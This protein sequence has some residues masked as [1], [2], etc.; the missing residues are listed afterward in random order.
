MENQLKE[1]KIEGREKI[2]FERFLGGRNSKNV[3]LGKV[4]GIGGEGVVIQQELE[5]TLM[6]GTY[7]RDHIK[8]ENIRLK[9]KEKKTVALKFVNFVK[10]DRENFQGQ[11][12]KNSSKLFYTL[13]PGRKIVLEENCRANF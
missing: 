1:I 4:L 7:S 3:D 9:S 5:I 10:E 6:E 12:L 2:S 13:S 11:S 8:V